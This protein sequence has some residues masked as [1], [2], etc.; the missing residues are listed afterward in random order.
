M[1]LTPIR[2]V[3]KLAAAF[4]AMVLLM[5]LLGAFG[6]QQLL[7]VDERMETIAG[8]SLPGVF[9]LGALQVAL[10][11]LRR[12]E[13]DHVLA[14]DEAERTAAAR[15]IAALR[16]ELDG[17]QSAYQA[18]I[19]ADD[20]RAGYSHYAQLRD[21]YFGALAETLALAASGTEGQA[22][23]NKLFHD[24]AG[25]F[26]EVNTALS[27]LAALNLKHAQEL[28]AQGQATYHHARR[29][30]L[31]LVGL[32]V[33]LATALALAIVRSVKRQLGGEPGEAARLAAHVAEGDLR[34]PI[35]LAPGDATSMMARLRTMQTALVQVV[36]EVRHNA[37]S[38]ATASTQIAQ[39]NADL[40]GRT[41]EQ[42]TALE[43]TAASMEQL[44]STVSRNAEQAREASRLAL[45]AAAIAGRGGEAVGAVVLTM[46]GI[47]HS[48]QRIAEISAVIDAIALQTNILAL[49]AAVEAARAGEEGRGF[50]VV[51]SE[52]RAL[53]HRAG[54]AAREIKTLIETS[55]ER[56]AEGSANV[57]RA[58]RT[59]SEAVDAVRRVATMIGEISTASSEQSAGVAQVGAAVSQMDQTTQ[60]NAALV[61]ESA[62]AADSLR[63]QAEQLVR[64]VSRFR[65]P[66]EPAPVSGA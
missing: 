63:Q 49:N 5:A 56:V 36:A 18:L 64:A 65:L 13:A 61:E 44:G 28:H 47:E 62:A 11:A 4:L 39:G 29:W 31:L 58:G 14:L 42:A 23:A 3:T 16:T 52:V 30:T 43:Q 51:A 15:Q 8:D 9:R 37:D 1:A 53:A 25:A 20:E 66:D 12:A 40:S 48:A 2:L 26:G 57:E 33:L 24:H 55:V 21:R 60:R 7:R 10:G 35:A 59:I 41:E 17:H 27:T 6:L 32:A 38:V 22:A 19:G 54:A 34:Q 50:A 45:D 46:Q